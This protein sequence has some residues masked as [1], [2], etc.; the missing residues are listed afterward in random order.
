MLQTKPKK[1][2]VRRSR[3]L[4]AWIAFE[5]D[6]SG[7]ECRV[8]DISLHGAKIVADVDT[9]IGS[10][11]YFTLVPNAQKANDAKSSGVAEKCSVSSSCRK[12]C[13]YRYSVRS[14]CLK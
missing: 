14:F 11:L 5:G 12:K 6:Q 10:R 8:M 2:E 3:Q 4:S 7:R 9:D 13:D 1:R